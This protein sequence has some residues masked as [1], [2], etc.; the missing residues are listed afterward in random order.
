M[1]LLVMKQL[2]RKNLGLNGIE[3]FEEVSDWEPEPHIAML[4]ERLLNFVRIIP[5]LDPQ[6]L[7]VSSEQTIMSISNIIHE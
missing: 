5:S 6:H 4:R 2:T 1:R 7:G 3:F